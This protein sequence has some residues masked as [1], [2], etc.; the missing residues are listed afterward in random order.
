MNEID[1]QVRLGQIESVI[2]ALSVATGTRNVL[3]E[4]LSR[5]KPNMQR[6]GATE[7]AFTLLTL[8]AS[9]AQ[10]TADSPPPPPP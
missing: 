7:D 8:L 2:V 3:V 10:A 6:L 9:A 5:D 4:A 1:L